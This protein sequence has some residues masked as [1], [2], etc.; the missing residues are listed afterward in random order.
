M[1]T[2]EAVAVA[3][4]R[5]EATVE[6]G[7]GK[8][9]PMA[10]IVEERSVTEGEAPWARVG[11]LPGGGSMAIPD[12]QN[13]RGAVDFGMSEDCENIGRLRTSQPRGAPVVKYSHSP[14]KDVSLKEVEKLK[15]T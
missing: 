10:A 12:Q 4:A 8:L 7:L 15:G 2:L 3:M 5:L 1:S 9:T 14:S 13:I 11:K 6:I